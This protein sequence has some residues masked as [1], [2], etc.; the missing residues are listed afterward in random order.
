MDLLTRRPPSDGL[1]IKKARAKMHSPGMVL[2]RFQV[3]GKA[4]ASHFIMNYTTHWTNQPTETL[5]QAPPATVCHPTSSNN[6]HKDCHKQSNG[7]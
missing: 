6:Y 3:N 1:P 7:Q 4:A 5:P 2:Y